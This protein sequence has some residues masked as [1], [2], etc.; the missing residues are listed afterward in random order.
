MRRSIPKT[1]FI[2]VRVSEPEKARLVQQARRQGVTLTEL[3]LG[4]VR[5][6]AA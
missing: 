2:Q 6:A 1:R 4:A 5:Q 3:L